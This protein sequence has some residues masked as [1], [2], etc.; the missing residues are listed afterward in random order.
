MKTATGERY[1]ALIVEDEGALRHAMLRTFSRSGFDC[2][3]AANGCQALE[4]VSQTKFDAVI[5]DLNMPEMNGHR[6]A[7]ELMAQSEPPLVIVVTGVTEPKLER[8]LRS[9]GVA[10][11]LFKPIN[12]DELVARTNCLLDA[13]TADLTPLPASQ[14]VDRLS[15][16]SIGEISLCDA[17]SHGCKPSEDSLPIIA[18]APQPNSISSAARSAEQAQHV[19]TNSSW[20]PYVLTFAAGIWMGWLMGVFAR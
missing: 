16:P 18:T 14:A 8:D 11:I 10:D 15:N 19:S 3:V 4:L 6:L 9:R 12:Y 20:L 1:R 2:K 17:A 7:V 5:T 13:R